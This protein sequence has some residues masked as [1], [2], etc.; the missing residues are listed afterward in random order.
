ML[1]AP[2]GVTFAAAPT[3]T[4]RRPKRAPR[5]V[6]LSAA[7]RR[8]VAQPTWRRRL[9]SAR[10][11][12]AFVLADAAWWLRH[13]VWQVPR[14]LQLGRE[15]TTLSIRENIPVPAVD[16]YA[17]P[18][19]AAYLRARLATVSCAREVPPSAPTPAPPDP[20]VVYVHGGAWGAGAASNYAQLAHALVEKAA[21]TVLVLSYRLYPAARMDHQ[22]DDVA[23]ALRYARRLFPARKLAVLAHSSGAHL[24]ALALLRETAGPEQIPLADLAIFSAGPFHLMHHFLFEATRGVADVSPML[25]A[26]CAEDDPRQFDQRSPTLIAEGYAGILQEPDG[27]APG[28]PAL[29]GELAAGNVSLP[30]ACGRPTEDGRKAL[31]PRTY[32]MTSSCDTTVPMYSS[33]RF[34][35][36]LRKL[37]LGCKL[38]VYDFVE[39]VDFVTDWFANVFPRDKSDVLDVGEEDQKRRESCVKILQ[40][41]E[42]VALSKDKESELGPSPHVRDVLR[43]LRSLRAVATEGAGEIV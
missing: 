23:A 3:M 31:F 6:F 4:N 8:A 24:T 12:G 9:R 33:L 35:T 16:V 11:I 10:T 17:P 18:A 36:A 1:P 34:V 13:G 28:P 37:G 5:P 32:V 21:A 38:L 19:H 27:L 14:T 42:Y 41:Q 15:C 22:A 29:E 43:I 39:H 25:P 26:A 2:A 7:V 20:V 40:G 30:D